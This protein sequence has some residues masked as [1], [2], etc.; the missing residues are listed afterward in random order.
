MLLAASPFTSKV[1][2]SRKKVVCAETY[3]PPRRQV[4]LRFSSRQSASTYPACGHSP[5]QDGEPRVPVL[6]I[7]SVCDRPIRHQ[8]FGTP[9]RLS[10]HL[11]STTHRNLLSWMHRSA[12]PAIVIRSPSRQQD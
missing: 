12:H 4:V 10:G 6:I 11:V 2:P 7:R 8:V 3:G 5:G 9:V 1:V